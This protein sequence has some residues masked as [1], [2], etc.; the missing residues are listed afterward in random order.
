MDE[1]GVD[2]QVRDLQAGGDDYSFPSSSSLHTTQPSDVGI[3]LSSPSDVGLLSS[4]MAPPSSHLLESLSQSC[5]SY[6]IRSPPFRRSCSSRF[7]GGNWLHVLLLP[8]SLYSVLLQLAD[9]WPRN[10]PSVPQ[11]CKAS[12]EFP[13]PREIRAVFHRSSVSYTDRVLIVYSYVLS[14]APRWLIFPMFIRLFQS[15]SLP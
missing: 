1:L 10:H 6:H 8:Y 4:P 11:P 14:A 2:L 15:H 3:L 12:L 5:T 9:R 13:G 7:P